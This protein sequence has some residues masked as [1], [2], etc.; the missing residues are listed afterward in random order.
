MGKAVEHLVA[1]AVHALQ[2][3]DE[4]A[5]QHCADELTVHP[6]VTGTPAADRHLTLSLQRGVTDAWKRG[7][8]PADLVRHAGREL[9]AEHAGLT[10]DMVAAELRA[11]SA[12][13]IDEQWEQQLAALGAQVWW[14]HDD[15]H[16]REWSARRRV[17]RPVM[18]SC[19]LELLHLLTVLPRLAPL[20]PLPGA[21]RRTV[22]APAHAVDQKMLGRVRALLA[23]A[24]STE[25]PEEAEAL[26]SRAQE[27]MTRHSI[28]HALLAADTGV[29]DG[30]GGRRLPVDNPYEAPKA[31]LLDVVASANRCRAIWHRELGFSAVLGFPSD[32][33]AV[34][35]LYTSLLVQ[36]T[37]AL[38][39]AGSRQDR[40]GRSRT[41][42]F[43]QSFLAA[44]ASRIGERLQETNGEVVRQASAESGRDLLPVL[45]ARDLVVD[46]A[47]ETMFPKLKQHRMGSIRDGEGWAAGRAAADL[48]SL[49]SHSE[50]TGLG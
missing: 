20:G 26:S 29:T 11:Y 30:P 27:L 25:F 43:R 45:A 18:I 1:E 9:G 32:L 12:A 3:R 34:E 28:D 31:V 38:V 39:H 24:E 49:T 19:A 2:R 5:F 46:R 50:I 10:T 8:Q 16:L 47:V 41:R 15:H 35:L 21:A 13:T 4:P 42:T 48:A 23:K 7:W 36:A 44:Y 37:T 22:R 17:A 40:L 14:E 33:D 6:S